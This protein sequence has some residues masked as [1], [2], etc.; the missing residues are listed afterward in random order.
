[1]CLRED[2]DRALEVAAEL[3]HHRLVIEQGAQICTSGVECAPELDG[4]ARDRA[5]L[6]VLARTA[7]HER[8][9]VER[10]RIR[11]RLLAQIALQDRE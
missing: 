1:V 3:Q 7:E 8:E 9:V 4:T 2:G 5:C 10:V 11:Q 6:R